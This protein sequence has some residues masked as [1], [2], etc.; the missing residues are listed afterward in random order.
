MQR[1]EDHNETCDER[2]EE[3]EFTNTTLATNTVLTTD[4]EMKEIANE[5]AMKVM[6]LFF[7]KKLDHFDAE[8]GKK[9]LRT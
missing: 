2:V 6:T 5:N 3:E 1:Y 9:D 4:N 7:E 8:N